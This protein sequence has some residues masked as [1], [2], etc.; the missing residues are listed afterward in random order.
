[1]SVRTISFA[2]ESRLLLGAW[3]V[4][5]LAGV[6]SLVPVASTIA[7]LNI[8]G[9]LESLV[10]FGAMFGIPL[11]ATLAF[12]S[13]FQYRTMPML[14]AQPIDR[15]E[16]WREK[17]A[18]SVTAVATTAVVYAFA[19]HA[20]DAQRPEEWVSVVA[21]A[22]VT[23]AAA[24][25][26][27]FIARSMIGG[28]ALNLSGFFVVT[29][30]LD[31]L[32]YL[33]QTSPHNGYETYARHLRDLPAWFI[34][35]GIVVYAGYAAVMAWLGRRGLL[36]LQAVDG[37]QAGDAVLPGAQLFPRFMADW[38]RCRA[39]GRLL[40]LVRREFH[41][42]RIVW[43]LGVVCAAMWTAIALFGLM[44][45]P[46]SDRFLMLVGIAVIAN[47]VIAV[48]A[49]AI[50]LGEEKTW[51]THV[52]HMTL[53]ISANA[54]WA[55]KLCVAL[56]TSIVCAVLVPIAILNLGG[57][58]GGPAHGLAGHGDFWK[59]LLYASLLTLAAFWSSCTVKGTV[60]ATV[61][62]IPTGLALTA[63][64]L[65]VVW[66]T[67][68]GS[69]TVIGWYD[70]VSWYSRAMGSVVAAIGPMRVYAGMHPIVYYL[71]GDH[72]NDTL[73]TV[74]T[75]IA[76]I[77][78]RRMFAARREETNGTAVRALVPVVLATAFCVLALEGLQ[79]IV[80][81]SYRQQEQI[82]EEMHEAIAANIGASGEKVK[83]FTWNDLSRE[84]VLSSSARKWLRNAS[85]TVVPDS[86]E[87]AALHHGWPAPSSM[88]AVVP[89]SKAGSIGGYSAVVRLSN[90]TDC[91]FK[92]ERARPS[93][94]K[95]F[96]GFIRGTCD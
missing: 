87:L 33:A 3:V 73:F 60:R 23:L 93:A 31:Y 27:T 63:S 47:V 71:F 8:H 48:L 11:L 86:P 68:L 65:F 38:F 82:I 88:G 32:A 5:M 52:W 78:T 37:M 28:L 62:V 45:T 67:N 59:M 26:F 30:I 85:I 81:Q 91:S 89:N 25:F 19:L 72:V 43:T 94:P 44:P 10:P 50:S 22:V 35:A 13:E 42:L 1:M 18:V 84:S 54:Q 51:G 15:R 21:I 7:G 56:F 76:L 2:K 55:I 17:M 70:R 34:V 49:G 69:V 40:N 90:G 9:M 20:L 61:W 41:L 66:I 16:I 95:W 39:R 4:V 29:L 6:F 57:G 24:P 14:L 92:Y 80:I 77:Q 75:G 83:S 96:G 53:P 12:G 74:V 58:I 36:Q 46:E 79:E 64:A